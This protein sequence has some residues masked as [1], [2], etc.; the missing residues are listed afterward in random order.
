M[1][2]RIELNFSSDTKVSGQCMH[3]DRI[4]SQSHDLTNVDWNPF[5]LA[6]TEKLS[7]DFPDNLPVD[8]LASRITSA[9]LTAGEKC[10]GRRDNAS[11]KQRAKLPQNLVNELNLKRSLEKQWKSKVV[12]SSATPDELSA[13][14]TAFL[15]QKTRA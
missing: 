8:V 4:D 11:A 1:V 12:D 6:V 5:K 15:N 10:I 9:L 3:H 13:C 2:K 14:E 7:P